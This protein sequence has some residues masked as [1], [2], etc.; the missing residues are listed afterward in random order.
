MFKLTIH[1]EIYEDAKRKVTKLVDN[2]KI[3]FYSATIQASKSS[4]ELFHN[5][6]C[7]HGQIKRSPLPS[8][9]DPIRLPHIF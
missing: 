3:S 1:K 9:F 6:K 7:I 4:K 5:L 2:T 8:G